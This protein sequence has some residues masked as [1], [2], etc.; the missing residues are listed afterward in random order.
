MSKS[1]TNAVGIDVSARDLHVAIEGLDT[2]LVFPNSVEGHTKLVKRITKAGR[3]ARVVLEATGLYHL[4]LALFLAQQ[5]RCEVMVANPR[6]THAFQRARNTR[7]KTDKVDAELLLKFALTMDF[8]PWAAPDSAVLELR[9][10]ARYHDQLI[11]EKVRLQ[12]QLSSVEAT[13][14]SPGWVI[15]QLQRRLREAETSLV[16]A[17]D[18]ME[19]H[20]EGHP[21]IRD[22]IARLT[23]IPGVGVVTATRLVAEFLL[24][25]PEMSSK[26][27]TAWAGLDP[28]PR[29]SGTSVRGR[30]SISKQGSSR[31]RAA[32][33]MS[34]VASCRFNEPF[35]RLYQRISGPEGSNKPG[36]VGIVALMRKLLIVAWALHR[37][38]SEWSEAKASSRRL[39]HAA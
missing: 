19:Q 34:A 17:L 31:V 14:A 7:A 30:R 18:R 4:D 1:K 11:K 38:K 29:E 21:V 12:T 27:I 8:T 6:S 16:E 28:R 2:V 20:S 10:Y 3:H 26:E 25:D 36:K 5:G 22:A 15:E 24:L 32:L 9:G 35:R 39:P 13:R 23:T 37:T 33:Y